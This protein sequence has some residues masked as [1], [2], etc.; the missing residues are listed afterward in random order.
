GIVSQEILL[1][2]GTVWENIAYGKPN[3]TEEEIVVAAKLAN[4]HEFIS[5]LS[6]G[7]ESEVGERGIKL[8][9]GQRQ[10]I[11][12]A[13][14]LLKDPKVLILDEATSSLDTESEHLI[15]NALTTL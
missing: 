14:A 13:R 15:Q 7:Y 11:S 2:N 8:S 3:A 9:G 12:I 1:L 4:A 10:R 6:L 5:S